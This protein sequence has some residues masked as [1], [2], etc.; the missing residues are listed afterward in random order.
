MESNHL[1]EHLRQVARTHAHRT[2]LAFAGQTLT[3]G[4]LDEQVERAAAYL[5][6][7]GIEA[8]D[9]VA[10]LLPNSD[11]FVVMMHAAFRI[12]AAVVPLNPLYP[13]AEL[14]YMLTDSG[15]RAVIAPVQVAAYAP[16]LQAQSPG[17]VI[18]A[19]G[20][21]TDELPAGVVPYAEVIAPTDRKVAIIARPVTDVAVI[22]Y[23][24][25]TTGRPK[26]VLLSHAN[27]G[28]NA[29]VVGD[30]LSYGPNDTVVVA[31]PLFHVFSLTVCLNA[32]IYR[33]ARM[34]LL[35][36]FSPKEVLSTI[37]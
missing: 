21:M 28:W 25:G 16:M 22:L 15:A 4:E 5:G 18:V 26:G 30:Y 12:G 33:G 13:P 9:R 17:I 20:P 7:A 23:T 32:S 29:Q 6:D 3:Y 14:L 24:S 36:N 11:A 37:T 19:W 2:A 10:L 8:G 1:G 31:L 34:I 27:L 35:P